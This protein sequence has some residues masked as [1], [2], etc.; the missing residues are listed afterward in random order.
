M[1]EGLRQWRFP[2]AYRIPAGPLS[3][4]SE[5]LEE[6]LPKLRVITT[7]PS[8]S[9]NRETP[10]RSEPSATHDKDLAELC[11]SLWRSTKAMSGQGS[12]EAEATFRRP[13]RHANAAL[14]SL[15][16][17]GLEIIDHTGEQLPK[18]GAYSLKVISFEP[19]DGLTQDVVLET[20][21]PTVLRDGR[22]IQMGEI[23]VGTPSSQ[24]SAGGQ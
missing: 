1:L 8:E 16:Q 4:V 11:T 14:E 5:L 24:S 3:P 20:V 6:L 9:P 17:L 10:E 15:A 22:R 18:S 23:I 21:R 13:L 19:K 7:V 2:R 12:P